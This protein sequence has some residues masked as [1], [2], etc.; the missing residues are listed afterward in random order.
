M[1]WD[2]QEFAGRLKMVVPDERGH[3]Y[4]VERQA[5]KKGFVT[6]KMKRL[7]SRNGF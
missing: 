3:V 5:G 2:E 1:K 6:V 7:L 4:A